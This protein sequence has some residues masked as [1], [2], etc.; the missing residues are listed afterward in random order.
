MDAGLE[1]LK[2]VLELECRKGY[3]DTAVMGGLDGYLQRLSIQDGDSGGGVAVDTN[4]HPHDSYAAMG[5]DQRRRWVEEVLGRLGASV[6]NTAGS[7]ARAPAVKAS[8]SSES[9]PS[10]SLDSPI[11]SIKGIHSGLASRFAKLGVSTIRDLLYFFPHRH[12]DFRQIVPI[13]YL[14]PGTE[15]TAIGIIWEASTKQIGS[16]AKGTEAILGDET[17]NIRAVWFNNPYLAKSLKP[18]QRVALSGRV[19]LFRG[20]KVFESPDYEMLEGDDQ[21]HTG[22]LVPVYPLTEGLYQR[23]VRGLVRKTLDFWA[24]RLPEFLPSS[25]RQRNGL[26]ELPEAVL[27]AHYP[28]GDTSKD[29]ARRRL[30]FDELLLMQLR[31][32]SRKR[33]WQEGQQ[34]H[35]LKHD[36][37]LLARFLDTLPFTLT[38]AQ[39]RAM[40]QVLS[41]MEGKRPMSRL[42]Q[43]EVGSGK[44]V[45]ATVALQ[46]AV[47]CGYQGAIMAPTEILAE[48][49][50]RTICSLLGAR[51]D[52]A[53]GNECIQVFDSFLQ[54]PVQVGLL[55]SDI[56]G[57]A[58]KNLQ[59][60]ISQGAV[61]IVIGTHA[62]IQKEVEFHDLALVVVDEQHRF[63]VMQR[64]ALRQKGTS[65]HLLVMTATPIP[66]TLA[67]TLYGDLEISVI[68]ELPPGRQ[69]TTTKWVPPQQRGKAYDF[70]RKQVQA[71]RQAFIVCPLIEESEVVQTRAAT[72]EYSRLSREIFPDLRL[73]LLHGRLS[74]GEK[75]EVMERFRGG[76]LDILVSTPVVEVGID[77]PNATVMMVEGAERF[78]LSQLHQ[79]R[80]RVGRGSEKSYCLLLAESL[81]REVRERLALMELTNDGFELAE[82][83]LRLRGP[84]EFFGTRQSGL[85]DLRMARLS[86]TALLELARKEAERLFDLDPELAE[87][88]HRGLAKELDRFEATWSIGGAEA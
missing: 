87:V 11:T 24:H 53:W 75:E 31:V 80:G 71:R 70:L 56:R 27:Q 88:E 61:D 77:I 43:G 73:G 83:D 76:E 3:A 67:L 7:S 68:D 35:P 34:A 78:G 82:E 20:Q 44:T 18:N 74:A 57:K 8:R 62:L 36:P 85:P 63:G 42:L 50:F 58:K 39:Q 17:G 22:R 6:P 86:D 49:H 37:E 16:R 55:I 2:K 25:I 79:F 64:S 14:V 47:A 32:L 28:D 19:G 46:M 10:L 21:I 69:E 9:R 54:R 30:A 12:N 41:D 84:G 59:K 60:L 72:Q 65:P 45:V 40:D 48:Q 33:E 4:L 29:E 81:S 5:I 26:P 1:Q 23:S 13:A 38:G 51:P 52:A 66:R 15:Q